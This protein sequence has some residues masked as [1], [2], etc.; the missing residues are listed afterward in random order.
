MS[1]EGGTGEDGGGRAYE[2]V[3]VRRRAVGAGQMTPLSFSVPAVYG[4]IHLHSECTD[5]RFI[6][7]KE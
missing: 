7:V 6:N 2:C 4:F 3:H 1:T 5:S